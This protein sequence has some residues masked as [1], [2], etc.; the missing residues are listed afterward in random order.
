[1]TN[2]MFFAGKFAAGAE[3]ATR[4]ASSAGAA[5]DAEII[6]SRRV[7]FAMGVS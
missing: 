6:K 7:I 3:C 5:R 1:M 4:G 2:W